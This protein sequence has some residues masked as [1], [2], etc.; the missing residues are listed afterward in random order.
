MSHSPVASPCISHTATR[1]LLDTAPRF[2]TCSMTYPSVLHNFQLPL[3]QYPRTLRPVN[4][5]SQQQL[6]EMDSLALSSARSSRSPSSARPMA[7]SPSKSLRSSS[8]FNTSPLP[9]RKPGFSTGMKLP[10][11]SPV[12]ARSK[13]TSRSLQEYAQREASGLPL[14]MPP[15]VIRSLDQIPNPANNVQN[16][17]ATVPNVSSVSLMLEGQSHLQAE[18]LSSIAK[19][20]SRLWTVVLAGCSNLSSEVLDS[21]ILSCPNIRVLDVS[22][23]DLIADESIGLVLTKLP[24]LEVLKAASCS[25]VTGASVATVSSPHIS[26]VDFSFCSKLAHIQ[27]L[28]GCPRLAEL[29]ISGCK[30]IVTEELLAVL[31]ASSQLVSLSMRLCNQE[32]LGVEA[33]KMVGKRNPQLA[34]LHLSG[35]S[36]LTDPTAIEILK[37]ACSESLVHVDLSGCSAIGD[38]TL[39]A[40]AET[41]CRSLETI[42]LS[43]TRCTHGGVSTVLKKGG[44]GLKRAI[45]TN[46][47]VTPEDAS[48]LREQFPSCEIVLEIAVPLVRKQFAAAK[49]EDKKKKGKGKKGKKKK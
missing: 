20:G 47:Q 42:V 30:K 5:V 28:A 43:G 9:V 7:Q 39:Y 32:A 6:P 15:G 34:R 37:S 38:L 26:S 18:A 45:V 10:D 36:Q 11:F 35:V 46:T 19:I 2:S 41:Q 24:F 22:Q 21:I 27:W 25:R 1:V 31:S 23:C 4:V 13:P 49:V 16:S 29:D 44:S 33:F 48:T 8:A 14:H 3:T 12:S 40:L 17:G